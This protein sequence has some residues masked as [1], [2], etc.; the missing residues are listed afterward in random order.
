MAGYICVVII[1]FITLLEVAILTRVLGFQFH[2]GELRREM[3]SLSL[4]LSSEHC[5]VFLSEGATTCFACDPKNF[6]FKTQCFML[7][8][9]VE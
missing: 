5:C 7:F 9:L 2:S 3:S 4:R 1:Y 6:G 8:I